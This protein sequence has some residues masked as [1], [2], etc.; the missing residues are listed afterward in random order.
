M[1]VGSF[2]ISLELCHFQVT[3]LIKKA[4][5]LFS[6]VR[7]TGDVYSWT[8]NYLAM[9]SVSSVFMVTII[10]IRPS[11]SSSS[12]SSLSSPSSSSIIS[13]NMYKH[14]HRNRFQH[15]KLITISP[16]SLLPYISICN[17]HH[18]NHHHHHIIIIIT[19]IITFIIIVFITK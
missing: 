5:K 6:A 4:V 18:H 3:S 10:E 8:F 11:S 17:R 19:I 13:I 7:S 15:H 2:W 9:L 12:L 1:K 16:P 14:Q